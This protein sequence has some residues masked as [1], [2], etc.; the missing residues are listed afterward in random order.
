MLLA[1]LNGVERAER[2]DETTFPTEGR[3]TEK[4]SP[5]SKRVQRVSGQTQ[6]TCDSICE[7]SY[8]CS[9]PGSYERSSELVV[10]FEVS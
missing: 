10:D 9:T 7:R 3:R 6:V 8:R 2:A 4:L 5:P 1:G